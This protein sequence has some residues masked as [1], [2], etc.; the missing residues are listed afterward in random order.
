MS[1]GCMAQRAS[2]ERKKRRPRIQF[3]GG[4]FALCFGLGVAGYLQDKFDME[5]S[6]CDVYGISIGNVPALALLLAQSPA[7]VVARLHA[8]LDHFLAGTPVSGM[9]G[10]LSR[11]REALHD[12]LPEDVHLIVGDRFH[13]VVNHW[14][15]GGLMEV[16]LF[17]SKHQLIEAVVVSCFFPSFVWRPYCQNPCAL[18]LCL[19]L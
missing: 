5:A 16:N 11:L 14:P 8:Y 13:V 12:W 4:G 15:T 7:Q 19:S 1:C 6:G 18:S 2:I 9:C 17:E 3:D 10:S